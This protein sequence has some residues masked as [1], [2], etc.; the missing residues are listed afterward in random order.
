MKGASKMQNYTNFDAVPVND[1]YMATVSAF[2]YSL[3]IMDAPVHPKCFFYQNGFQIR[4]VED[5]PIGDVIIHDGSYGRYSAEL[6]SY[7][8]PWDYG[9]VSCH[10]PVEMAR[11]INAYARGED[12]RAILKEED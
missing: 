1:T 10:N 6:E 12:W 3:A 4:F 5:F 7:G 9:D 11:L 2:L 8:F